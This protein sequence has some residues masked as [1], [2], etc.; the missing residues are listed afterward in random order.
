MARRKPPAPNVKKFGAPLYASAWIDDRVA[1][2]AGGGGK[3]SS[4]IPNRVMQA[5]FDSVELTEP[6][7]SVHTDE[8][9]PQVLCAHPYGAELLVAFSGDVAVYVV[10]A[11]DAST[12]LAETEESDAPPPEASAPYRIS[13]R[14]LDE[15]SGTA[16][17]VTLATCD[18]K[19]AAFSPDG[20]SLAVGLESG[21]VRLFAWPT[22]EPSG[23][24]LDASHADAV[25]GVAFSPDG[26]RLL[27]TS[28]ET[29]KDG[30]GP[31]VWNVSTGAKIATLVDETREKAAG[32]ARFGRQYRFCGFTPCGSFAITGLNDGGEG[33]V[34]KWACD[35]WKPHGKAQRVTREPLSAM[36]FDPTGRTVACGNS[37]GHVVVV[38][39]KTLATRKT[40]RGAHMIFVTT[41]AYSPD[42]C[43]VLSGSADAS[44][45]CTVV[46]RRKGLGGGNGGGGRWGDV[47][48]K[49]YALLVAAVLAWLFF[50]VG[51][52]A[53]RLHTAA[54]G[55]DAN[56]DGAGGDVERIDMLAGLKYG[57]IKR[58]AADVRRRR[59]ERGDGPGE[60]P[61]AA[62]ESHKP[63]TDDT[64]R[65]FADEDPTPYECVDGPNIK[66]EDVL[67]EPEAWEMRVKKGAPREDKARVGTKPPSRAAARAA[68]FE[69][70]PSDVMETGDGRAPG[71]GAPGWGDGARDEL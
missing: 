57:D 26:T 70:V 42:G 61:P 6:L 69:P 21:E 64:E 55:P 48:E 66:C 62:D 67:T 50:T 2:V 4:G 29:V 31:A 9:A 18:V 37:E 19:C 71:L 63:Q 13:P 3:K 27:S 44:A 51:R 52:L 12:Q 39:V 25:N 65:L 34:C 68:T 53:M 23:V 1:L 10:T 8:T 38:D 59:E 58:L 56:G 41:M 14:D 28:S 7:A 35:T 43:A 60:S 22:L 46:W 17:R 36:A 33:H 47:A 32:K 15:S 5:S 40:I 16:T 20:A 11:N 54:V 30:R 24:R 49:A 45:C